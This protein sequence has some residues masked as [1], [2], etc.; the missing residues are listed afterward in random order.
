M[1]KKST[2]F[3]ERLAATRA[4][5]GWSLRKLSSLCGHSVTMLHRM[6]TG[7]ISGSTKLVQ[8]AEAL[9]V[10]VYWLALGREREDHQ[11]GE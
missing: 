9:G 11:D 4:G 6:E 1:A 8:L 7:N 10:D 2:T 5:K 3:A